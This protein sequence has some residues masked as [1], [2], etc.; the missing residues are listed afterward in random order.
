MNTEISIIITESIKHLIQN[1]QGAT[2]DDLE[3]EIINL[4]SYVYLRDSDQIDFSLDYLDQDIISSLSGYDFDVVDEII[5]R[6]KFLF[7]D[8]YSEAAALNATQGVRMNI[9]LM[10]DYGSF[11]KSYF[12]S[13]HKIAD[14][15]NYKFFSSPLNSLWYNGVKHSDSHTQRDV[16]Y[17]FDSITNT[18]EVLISPFNPLVQ[19]SI[20]SMNSNLIKC[21]SNDKTREFEFHFIND[22]LF[23]VVM[24]RLDKGDTV[25]YH[26]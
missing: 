25:K 22:H 14:G 23:E 26:K 8:Y 5:N 10:S 15:N 18:F 7:P 21:L 13:K 20:I 12:I 16:N 11:L 1:V 4:A 17:K 6:T 24:N 19:G 3:A 2:S 9:H